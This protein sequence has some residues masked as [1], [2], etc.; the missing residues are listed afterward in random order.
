[1]QDA[2]LQS[3]TK[4]THVEPF[5]RVVVYNNIYEMWGNIITY[6]PPRISGNRPH[7]APPKFS[8]YASRPT[9][10]GNSESTVTVLPSTAVFFHGT[11]RG[12]QSVVPP[13][14]NSSNQPPPVIPV[15]IMVGITYLEVGEVGS[16]G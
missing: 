12:A 5:R 6:I 15:G 9:G 1:M 3:S 13:N 4:S 11:Y 7:A 16:L 14:T 2:F 8:V 10:R